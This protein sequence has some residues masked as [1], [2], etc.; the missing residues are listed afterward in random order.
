M[1]F[2]EFVFR[3]LEFVDS[4]PI[5]FLEFLIVYLELG[6]IALDQIGDTYEEGLESRDLTQFVVFVKGNVLVDLGLATVCLPLE[7]LGELV[8]EISIFFVKRCN[9]INSCNRDKDVCNGGGH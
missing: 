4:L 6:D 9:Y 3:F 5:I 1:Y 7:G 2:L 8:V